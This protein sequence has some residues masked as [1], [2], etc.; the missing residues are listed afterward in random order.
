MSSLPPDLDAVADSVISEHWAFFVNRRYIYVAKKKVGAQMAV[1]AALVLAFELPPSKWP[2]LQATVERARKRV[3]RARASREKGPKG[4][5]ADEANDWCFVIRGKRITKDN[6]VAW[7]SLN[8]TIWATSSSS[9]SHPPP[10]S[11]RAVHPPTALAPAKKRPMDELLPATAKRAREEEEEDSDGMDAEEFER[12][13]AASIAAA[14]LPPPAEATSS[15]APST[16]APAPNDDPNYDPAYELVDVLEPG[17]PRLRADLIVLGEYQCS[18][19][20]NEG[21]MMFGAC[22]YRISIPASV[23][24][25]HADK[26]DWVGLSKS[27]AWVYSLRIGSYYAPPGAPPEYAWGEA[28]AERL[29]SDYAH[30]VVCAVKMKNAKGRGDLHASLLGVNSHFPDVRPLR[31]DLPCAPP[32]LPPRFRKQIME[33]AC[34]RLE[35]PYEGRKFNELVD[36][37]GEWR[38]RGGPPP[39]PPPPAPAPVVAEEPAYSSESENED[40]GGFNEC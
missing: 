2:D 7:L 22:R 4:S 23:Y 6:V 3:A 27:A 12:L 35:I 14:A 26:H 34:K 18:T 40:G 36:E 25:A 1:A 9:S 17:Q 5:G 37:L 16:P 11:T 15:P 32:S 8:H 38:R 28:P 19:W 33:A 21:G 31:K 20:P 13:Q 24:W 39:P 29:I 10:P 30:Q